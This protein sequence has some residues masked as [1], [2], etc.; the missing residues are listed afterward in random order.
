MSLTGRRSE[1][2]AERRRLAHQDRVSARL[3]ELSTIQT[4]LADAQER[5]GEGWAQGTWA[6]Y[7]GIC[8]VTSVRD[9]GGGGQRTARALDLVWHTLHDDEAGVRWV[10][11]PDVRLARVRDLARWNDRA[12]RRLPEVLALLAE[13]VVVAGRERVR[14][15]AQ[16][17]S[18]AASVP[19][20]SYA[21]SF[22]SSPT[23]PTTDSTSADCLQASACTIEVTDRIAP[24]VS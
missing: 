14:I 9:A 17:A 8:L 11:P 4:I 19:P 12:E 23:S 18:S 20:S 13:A 7:D 10:A 6:T 22:S 5:L 1:Q 15:W 2:W 3:A 16:S 24:S 21:R